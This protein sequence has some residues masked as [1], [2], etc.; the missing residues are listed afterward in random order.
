MEGARDVDEVRQECKRARGVRG[1]D[2]S[3]TLG[4]RYVFVDCCP[5]PAKEMML[6]IYCVI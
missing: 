6:V 2:R 4:G 1:V 3:N 5:I